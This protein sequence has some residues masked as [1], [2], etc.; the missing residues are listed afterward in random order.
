MTAKVE[1]TTKPSQPE[2][3]DEFMN[4]LRHPLKEVCVALRQIIHRS[5]QIRWR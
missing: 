2:A 5:G 3:V 1:L 4:K